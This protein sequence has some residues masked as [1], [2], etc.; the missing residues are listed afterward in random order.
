MQIM[1]FFDLFWGVGTHPDVARVWS[2]MSIQ[3]FHSSI[4]PL[5]SVVCT[6]RFAGFSS[7]VSFLDL[8]QRC[9]DLLSRPLGCSKNR[10]ENGTAS[11]N[12]ALLHSIWLDGKA[13]LKI[14]PYTHHRF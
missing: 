9:Q 5:G 11:G 3:F 4:V 7:D 10:H 6:E 1:S 12:I 2:S 14:H 13:S 8:D